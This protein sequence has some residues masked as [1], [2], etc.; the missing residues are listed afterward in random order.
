MAA[1]NALFHII[2]DTDETAALLMTELEKRKSGRLTFL[3]LNRLRVE[4]IQYPDSNDVRALIEVALDF[5]ENVEVAVRQVF[6]KKLLA[7]NL[8]TA[9]L[10]SKVLLVHTHA[11]RYP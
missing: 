4:N 9:S 1:G 6:G 5:N 3:P 8:E 11:L 7:K 10:F 2:V